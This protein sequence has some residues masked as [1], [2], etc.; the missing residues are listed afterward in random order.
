M[1]SIIARYAE[2]RRS[3]SHTM[4]GTSESPAI[5]AGCRAETALPGYKLIFAE[6][7]RAP[8][9]QRLNDTVLRDR[10]GEC[11]ERGWF[12]GHARL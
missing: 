1:F 9:R 7:D 11:G 2:R 12:E 10:I 6:A 3:I 5:D 4:H 8:H